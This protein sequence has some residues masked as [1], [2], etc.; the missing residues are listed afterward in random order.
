[1]SEQ[2][3]RMRELFEQALATGPASAAITRLVYCHLVTRLT[4]GDTDLAR[5]I[6]T[7][8]ATADAAN[9]ELEDLD[10][11]QRAE[12]MATVVPMFNAA[13]SLAV[14][15]LWSACRQLGYDPTTIDPKHTA[16]LASVFL[17]PEF[18]HLEDRLAEPQS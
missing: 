6:F 16:L 11:E 12:L 2:I 9:Q 3:D 14:N 5:S 15:H 4:N 10:D 17:G 7:D 18:T 1:M 8:P 13:Q